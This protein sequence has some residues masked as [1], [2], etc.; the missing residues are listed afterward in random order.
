MSG[1]EYL[2]KLPPQQEAIRARSLHPTS[3]LVEFTK[4]EAEQSIPQR[5]EKIVCFYPDRLA[6]KV[7]ARSLT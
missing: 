1:A 5:F 2:S 3:S 6:V 4:E 7:G